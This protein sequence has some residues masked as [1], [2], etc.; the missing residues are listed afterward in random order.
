MVLVVHPKECLLVQMVLV[1][2]EIQQVFLVRVSPFLNRIVITKIQ[3]FIGTHHGQH[4]RFVRFS[5]TF[6]YMNFKV[7]LSFI[8]VVTALT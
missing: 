2:T 1:H 4:K 6:F 3:H 7:I 5:F 8:G